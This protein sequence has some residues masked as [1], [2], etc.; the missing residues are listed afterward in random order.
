MTEFSRRDG[1]ERATGDFHRSDIR[2]ARLT[3]ELDQL[4][5]ELRDVQRSYDAALEALH[6]QYE[7]IARVEALCEMSEWALSVA[8]PRSGGDPTVRT[9]DLRRALRSGS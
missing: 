6:E 1:D 3:T 5:S 7:R 4:R 2:L 8:D 9:D